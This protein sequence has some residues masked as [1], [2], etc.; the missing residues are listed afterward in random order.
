MLTTRSPSKVDTFTKYPDSKLWIDRLYVY[1]ESFD[2][3]ITDIS[4]AAH[5]LK[6]YIESKFGKLD[7]LINNAAQT[8]RCREKSDKGKEEEGEKTNR[9]GDPKFVKEKYINSWQMQLKDI[10]QFEMEEVYRVNAIAPVLIIQQMISLLKE[11][12]ENPYIINVMAREGLF[13]VR[14][15]SKK[16]IHLN[17]AKSALAQAHRTLV[18]CGFKTKENKKFRFHACDPGWI[19]IDEYYESDKPWPVP[20]LDEID[21]ASRILYPLIIELASRRKTC[22]HYDHYIY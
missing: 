9:Y 18:E 19:S 16:H 3:D 1:P 22:R 11:S 10:V 4:I 15:K 2:L 13:E 12:K 20:P 7:I 6:Q 14:F 21:G 8:I 17:M 5:K